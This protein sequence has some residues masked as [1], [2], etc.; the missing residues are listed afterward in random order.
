MMHRTF[1][2]VSLL[3]VCTAAS[4]Q[5]TS[6]DKA[7]IETLSRSRYT[8]L[9]ARDSAAF[10]KIYAPDYEFTTSWGTREGLNFLRR[11]IKTVPPVFK[12]DPSNYKIV[13]SEDGKIGFAVL[14]LREEYG[15]K[16]GSEVSQTSFTEIYAKRGGKW[17]LIQGHNSPKTK[18]PWEK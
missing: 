9:T 15:D 10:A 4:A 18:A 5:D 13:L 12:L 17:L 3:L 1:F 16:N 2:F 6:A 14:D 11:F 8:A 7:A